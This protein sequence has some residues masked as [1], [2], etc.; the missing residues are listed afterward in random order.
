MKI[1]D[2]FF[3]FFFFQK[4]MTTI[5][6]KHCEQVVMKNGFALNHDK[7]LRNLLPIRKYAYSNLQKIS[8]PKTEFFQIKLSDI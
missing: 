4:P 1:F 3:F 7:S 6:K 8:T 5:K 2:F